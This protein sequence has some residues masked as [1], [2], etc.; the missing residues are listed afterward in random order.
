MKKIFTLITMA[1]MA[2]TAM[3]EDYKGAMDIIIG[4]ATTPISQEATI[5][6]EE[7]DGKYNLALR[8]FSFGEQLQFGDILM[9]GMENEATDDGSVALTHDG[10]ITLG[11]IGAMFGSMPITLNAT[12]DQSN[13]LK[14][15]IAI[16]VPGVGDV[17]VDFASTPEVTTYKGELAIVLDPANPSKQ[18]AEIEVMKSNDIYTLTLKNFSFG[19][20]LQF[21]DIKMA[22]M[23]NSA[24]DGTVALKYDGDIT[25]DGIGAMFGAM[26]ITLDATVDQADVLNFDLKITIAMLGNATIPV[27][28]T[29]KE[30]TG[31]SS[32]ETE[33]EGSDEVVAIYD[34]QGRK[35]TDT[36]KKGIYILRKADGTTT[37]VY[38]K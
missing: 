22:G 1:V 6:L 13:V 16:T 5:S 7:Q 27:S 14:A 36:N 35:V 26:P 12:V 30:S 3:A 20:D 37:K 31:I 34:L 9:E 24:N 38:K 4:E 10:E 17:K 32:V 18:E 25:L 23:K 15:D 21:G 29:S 2:M 33:T 8:N 11:G 28:F 19:E